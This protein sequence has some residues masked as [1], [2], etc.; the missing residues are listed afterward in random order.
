TL[1]NL[2]PLEGKITLF[3]LLPLEE[4]ITLFNLLPLEGGG[5]RWGWGN[6]IHLCPQVNYLL[7]NWRDT[8][9]I[10]KCIIL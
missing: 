10:K 2:L 4:R 3:N 7:E 1:F 8:R 9:M 6:F 5:L